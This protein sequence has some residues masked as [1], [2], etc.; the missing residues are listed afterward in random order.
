MVIISET[1]LVIRKIYIAISSSFKSREWD[2]SVIC[3]NL[4]YIE[5]QDML[6]DDS[7]CNDNDTVRTAVAIHKIPQ[8]CNT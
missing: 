1:R 7:D 4:A 6:P 5:V 2:F 8:K 3:A